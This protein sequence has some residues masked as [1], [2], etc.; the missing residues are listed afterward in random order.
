MALSKTPDTKG[1]T[2]ENRMIAVIGAFDQKGT[3]G[4]GP[5]L[6]W[7]STE[8][9]SL[10]KKDMGRFIEKTRGSAP[11]GTR[12][13]LVIGRGTAEAMGMRPLPGRHMIVISQTL[14]ER[15]INKERPEDKK[16]AVAQ[17]VQQAI[18]RALKHNDCGHI[19]FGGGYEVWLQAI[20]SGF[21]TNAFT[22][23][24]MCDAAAMSPHRGDIRRALEMTLHE[25]FAGMF[26]TTT[27]E[28]DVWNDQPVKLKLHD[29]SK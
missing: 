16:I 14:N 7:G 15:E 9:R 25:T 18:E 19:F 3:Y 8:G 23:V 21:C 6:P 17:N 29:Y 5:H 22:T 28:D 10:L 4:I 20:K 12:N 24:A 2:M 11:E 13:V 26:V 27:E 1:Y